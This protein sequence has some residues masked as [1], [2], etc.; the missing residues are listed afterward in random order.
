M[1]LIRGEGPARP[2]WLQPG[3]RV[4]RPE[5]GELG[6]VTDDYPGT[7]PE[8]RYIAWDSGYT[9]WM[10]IE[11]WA[12][13]LEPVEE[14][15]MSTK[16]TNPKDALGCKKPPMSTIPAPVLMEV[17]AAMLEGHQKGYRRH[18]YRVSGVRMSIYYDAN[19]R[20]LMDW[21]EG[22]DIDP[23]S[24]IHH[25]SKA[26]AGLIVL[27]D[28]MMNDKALDDRPPKAKAGWMQRVQA[29]VDSVLERYPDEVEPYTELNKGDLTEEQQLELGARAT[30]PRD[31]GWSRGGFVSG[32]VSGG[33]EVP[34]DF[35]KKAIEKALDKRLAAGET[36]CQK[37]PDSPTTRH[38]QLKLE[39]GEFEGV[40]A[41][42]RRRIVA[43]LEQRTR[44]RD[45]SFDEWSA[46]ARNLGESKGDEGQGP[47][48]KELH[49]P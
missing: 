9:T 11:G 22:Q 14:E 40:C 13:K 1:S 28:A 37:I 5:S 41:E 16:E 19:M 35:V 45:L 12:D 46:L 2:E 6:T 44:D 18:N 24:G 10:S 36:G 48:D 15:N 30:K 4:R 21:W 49:Q 25:V 33:K 8:A 20:H 27:R 43:A 23:D 7:N 38:A 31:D 32:Y 39:P 34:T 42:E 29:Q 47:T 26:I 17:G 3:K